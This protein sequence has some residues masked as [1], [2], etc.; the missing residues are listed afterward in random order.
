MHCGFDQKMLTLYADG[1][2]ERGRVHDVAFHLMYCEECRRELKFV[3]TLGEAVRTLPHERAPQPLLDRVMSAYALKARRSWGKG[4][5]TTVGAVISVAL[6]GCRI[7][8]ERESDLRRELP[9][10]VAR[11]VMYV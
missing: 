6:R 3:W 1:E 10:W 7:D 4:T 2:L 8:E 11:W 9:A 5:R